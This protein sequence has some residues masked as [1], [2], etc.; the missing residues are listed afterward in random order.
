MRAH[1]ALPLRPGRGGVP[2][3]PAGGAFGGEIEGSIAWTGDLGDLWA[4]VP[5]PGHI[6]DGRADLDLRLGGS[7]DAPRL[8]GR[9]DLTD[10]QY[11]NLDA[12]TIL[13]DLTIHTTIAGDGTVNLGAGQ[14]RW[15]QGHG[16]GP[17]RA[18]PERRRALDRRDGRDR[19]RHPGA[20][21]RRD[22]AAQR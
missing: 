11:Q 21:R 8:S 14:L 16:H 17:R 4:L 9:A 15:R 5:A 18:A 19:P 12:G 10:G 22:G 6:L 2:E 1:L 20:P 3:V 7:L 13:T